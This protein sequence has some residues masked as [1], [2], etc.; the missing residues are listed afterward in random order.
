MVMLQV[1]SQLGAAWQLQPEQHQQLAELHLEAA[2]QCASSN[3]AAA[4]AAARASAAAHVTPGAAP[5]AAS[6]SAAQQQRGKASSR[7][8]RASSAGGGVGKAAVGALAGQQA[9]GEHL[10]EAGRHLGHVYAALIERGTVPPAAGATP[11]AAVDATNG[12]GSTA[13]SA[14]HAAGASAGVPPGSQRT[15]AAGEG[16][17]TLLPL[18]VSFAQLELPAQQQAGAAL[19][20][21]GRLLVG[22]QQQEPGTISS[23]ASGSTD[24]AVLHRQPAWR[25]GKHGRWQQCG[26]GG[27]DWASDVV[28]TQDQQK[29]SQH[30]VQQQKQQQ[31]HDQQQKQQPERELTA[32]LRY[33][34]AVGRLEEQRGSMVE[35]A[36]AFQRAL[37]LCTAAAAGVSAQQQRR[38]VQQPDAGQQQ[39]MDADSTEEE[40]MAAAAGEEEGSREGSA[41]AGCEVRLPGVARDAIISVATAALKQDT[42]A[43][44]L[45]VADVASC[46]AEG[47]AQVLVQRLVPLCLQGNDSREWGLRLVG[48]PGCQRGVPRSWRAGW[49]QAGAGQQLPWDYFRGVTEGGPVQRGNV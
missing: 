28:R 44:S 13:Q 43:T 6:A 23:D 33:W 18:A 16:A 41:C 10:D 26:G 19:R 35:A 24:A 2:V 27:D 7:S 37:Q 36:Q 15:L 38:N 11:L 5:S 39:A 45:L 46:L 21:P 3:G 9:A 34:W 47:R 4:A 20:A 40:A 30:E 42:V 29:H 22:L 32:A 17:Q 1:A 48:G 31:K 25:L 49:C 8:R 14:A 12:A